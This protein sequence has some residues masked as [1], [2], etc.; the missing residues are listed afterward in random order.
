MCVQCNKYRGD[1]KLTNTQQET[2]KD[3]VPEA[4]SSVTNQAVVA[5]LG[6]ESKQR[7]DDDVEQ[8]LV[9]VKEEHTSK[10]AVVVE[11]KQATNE[12]L[13]DRSLLVLT[14]LAL[15]HARNHG[16][17]YGFVKAS[18]HVASLLVKYF[19]MKKLA[20]SKEKEVTLVCD[21]KKCSFKY[22]FFLF[23]NPTP[24]PVRVSPIK[25]R[26]LVRLPT[27]DDTSHH[28]TGIA[29]PRKGPRLK[30]FSRFFTGVGSSSRGTFFGVQLDDGQI[31]ALDQHS[32]VGMSV[33]VPE[34]V[35]TPQ[36]DILK[37][38]SVLS[39]PGERGDSENDEI[40]SLLND[41]RMALRG[42]EGGMEPK[43]RSLMQC[44]LDER[45]KYESDAPRREEEER[46]VKAYQAILERRKEMDLAWQK[47]RDQDMDA[48]CD[49]CN[50]GEVTPDNQ[51]LFCEACNVAVHQMCYG[52]DRVPEG[53]YYCIAC[54]YFGREK[55][56]V[57][58]NRPGSREGANM[59]LAPSPLPICCELC[60]RKQGAFIR[61]DTSKQEPSKTGKGVAV[62]K[63]VHVVCAKWQGLNFV[64]EDKDVV[65]DVTDLK[66]S[67]RR[68]DVSCFLCKGNRGAF[69]K[70]R[71]PSCKR[72]FHVT[73]ARSYGR[74]EVVHG[75]NCGGPVEENPWTLLCPDHSDIPPEAIPERAVPVEDLV[76][77]AKEFP[78][79]P[80]FEQPKVKPNKVF[81]K[82]N[83]KERKQFLK[84]PEFENQFLQEV[85]KKLQGVRCEV[86]HTQ[87][88]DGKALTRC[89]SCG[90]VFCDS[91][92]MKNE[93]PENRIYKCA[94][95]Q[96]MEEEK[97]KQEA[98]G[99]AKEIV[100]P[101]CSLC[102]QKGGWL[103][104][105]YGTPM[106]KSNWSNKPKEFKRSLFGRNLWCHVLCTM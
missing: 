55:M 81:N 5:T 24:A 87:E 56:S 69:N 93:V 58:M 9:A 106:K 49:I 31:K 65:E 86:C 1:N 11:E 10:P 78:P 91:C 26:L 28:L 89:V 13:D 25:E 62:S 4:A 41:K 63:W 2:K 74:C 85:L 72:W 38:F 102:F 100:E 40:L 37:T 47:Q 60:P 92:H 98:D 48:V 36:W 97:S 14:A 21:L 23:K 46:L 53:D 8:K 105:A 96:Y 34:F 101:S 90:V 22:A 104:K 80:K 30:R 45:L 52:I 17:W 95:C 20:E 29:T 82:M 19:R 77:R 12:P 54:Q 88:D 35:L 94:A 79:E 64:D 68:A 51:I 16:I 18:P 57:A 44:V 3:E 103:R 99:E 70:C 33:P 42:L 6:E 50:D 39:S 32:R 15:E 71:V 76:L 84:D 66:M 67:F 75:E 73:C 43:I 7:R 83:G 27:V 59:K 61:T